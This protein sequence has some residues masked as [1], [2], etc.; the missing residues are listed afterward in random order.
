M[1][2]TT[3]Y[4]FLKPLDSIPEDYAI[5]HIKEPVQFMQDYMGW[6]VYTREK[7]DPVRIKFTEQVAQYN[8]IIQALQETPGF[9]DLFTRN[10]LIISKEQI[11]QE[12]SVELANL[13]FSMDDYEFI[14][15][16][17]IK[18]NY[19][20]DR[21]RM[22]YEYNIEQ[23]DNS[24]VIK[25]LSDDLRDA[26]FGLCLQLEE[27]GLMPEEIETEDGDYISNGF[28]WFDCYDQGR[29]DLDAPDGRVVRV[30]D[31]LKSCGYIKEYVVE[32]EQSQPVI[33]SDY[34][35]EVFVLNLDYKNDTAL[36]EQI[37]ELLKIG[38]FGGTSGTIQTYALVS[39]AEDDID[40]LSHLV[41]AEDGHYIS[42]N[43]GTGA[44]MIFN[45]SPEQIIKITKQFNINAF[46]YGNDRVPSKPYFYKK[47]TEGGFQS[48]PLEVIYHMGDLESIAPDCSDLWEDL[49]F[50][51]YFRECLWT[52]ISYNFR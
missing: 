45:L 11:E 49:Y 21:L 18:G 23:P 35:M 40:A 34:P 43:D 28:G 29:D 42:L 41:D 22:E 30:L 26:T 47:T 24:L 20:F 14:H 19:L 37:K 51:D 50:N 5:K 33:S 6:A 32:I 36:A 10:E 46:I 15:Q 31:L 3:I 12:F 2:S 13:V 7:S 27:D 39:S 4:A 38:I 44:G 17:N 48:V 1:E 8:R 25:N 16:L 9:L 52:G